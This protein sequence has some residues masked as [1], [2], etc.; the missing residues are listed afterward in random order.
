MRV[1]VKKTVLLVSSRHD[2]VTHEFQKS[3]IINRFHVC[4]ANYR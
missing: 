3:D 2:L 4:F 1:G